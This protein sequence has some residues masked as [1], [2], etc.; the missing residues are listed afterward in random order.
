METPDFLVYP[1]EHDRYKSVYSVACFLDSRLVTNFPE[2]HRKT[3]E[4]YE[5]HAHAWDSQRPKVLFEQSWLDRFVS[6]LPSGGNVLDVGCGAGEP[7]ARYLI[8]QRFNVTGIDAAPA[9]VEICRSRFPAQHW[10][11]MDMREMSLDQS[12]DG[13]IAWDSFFHLD[14]DEQ[15]AVLRRFRGHLKPGG[16]LMVTVGDQAGEVLGRV[17][18]VEVYHS[19]LAPEEYRA[20]LQTA[21]F[22]DVTLVLCDESCGGHSVLLARGFNGSPESPA[23]SGAP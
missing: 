7:I 14:P 16:A 9:M 10:R 4:T 6:C 19:S 5:E 20:I 23:R 2:I 22:E 8:D 21:G 11:V 12:F 15:R 1:N 18:G 17:N 3:V 13:I